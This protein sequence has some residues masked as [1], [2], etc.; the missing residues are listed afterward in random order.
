MPES[1]WALPLARHFSLAMSARAAQRAAL[2]Q[3]ETT[4]NLDLYGQQHGSNKGLVAPAGGLVVAA[5]P[6]QPG[7]RKHERSESSG[8]ESSEPTSQDEDESRDTEPDEEEDE[9][10][11]NEGDG[12]EVDEDVQDAAAPAEGAP[13]KR[14]RPPKPARKKQ[15]T[16]K[17]IQELQQGVVMKMGD[18]TFMASFMAESKVQQAALHS[19]K[20]KPKETAQGQG[21]RKA[22]KASSASKQKVCVKEKG[23]CEACLAMPARL[24]SPFFSCSPDSLPLSC[25]ANLCRPP[26]AGGRGRD[27]NNLQ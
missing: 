1:E 14:G 11:D 24:I 22:V 17:S 20:K 19:T 27:N 12:M 26:Q 13:K 15:K 3:R 2:I 16:K 25:K 21:S 5:T 8:H 4:L 7:S 9:E 18:A 23:C 6:H 10:E